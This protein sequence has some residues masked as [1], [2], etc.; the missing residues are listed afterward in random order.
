MALG[1]STFGNLAGAF[2]DI[3]SGETTAKSL[4][5]KASGDLAEADNYDIAAKLADINK[6]FTEQST[7]VKE[8]QN[9]RDIYLGLGKTAAD[10]TGAGFTMS[11]SGLD[12][13]RMGAQQGALTQQIITQQGLITEAGFESQAQ[14]YTNMA[15][16]ARYAASEENDLASQSE[17]NGWIT[18]G[19][20]GL[21][22]LS[23]LVL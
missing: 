4:R 1:Q 6:Q 13:M 2:Q 14:S 8:V 11:G 7:K 10:V 17:R 5:L 9:A 20:K 21:A 23:T 12:I 3:F 22:A 18:G 19:I 15:K 16:A